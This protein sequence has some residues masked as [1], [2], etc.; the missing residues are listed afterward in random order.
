[1]QDTAAQLAGDTDESIQERVVVHDH[2]N[3]NILHRNS[4]QP[5]RVLTLACHLLKL[6]IYYP[7]ADVT[8][9]ITGIGPLAGLGSEDRYNSAD[10]SGTG[11]LGLST[12]RGL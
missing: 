8:L 9:S 4:E 10:V 1:M 3:H 2:N 11:H 6:T 5:K 12:P 7:C